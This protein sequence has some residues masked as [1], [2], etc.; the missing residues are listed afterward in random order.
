M[1]SK[2]PQSRAESASLSG[3]MIVH[4]EGANLQNRSRKRAFDSGFTTSKA[5]EKDHQCRNRAHPRINRKKP[6]ASGNL[7]VVDVIVVYVWV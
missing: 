5:L 1:A 6:G 2:E 7:T 3:A 4:R